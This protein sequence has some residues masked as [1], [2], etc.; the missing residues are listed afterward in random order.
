MRDLSTNFSGALALETSL[1]HDLVWGV[2]GIA[3]EINR[4]PRQTFHLLE[5]GR[6]P[7]RKI[8]ARWCATRSALRQFFAMPRPGRSRDLWSKKRAGPFAAAGS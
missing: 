5:N 3:K 6:I 7:A 1:E 4:S 8:G 2:S